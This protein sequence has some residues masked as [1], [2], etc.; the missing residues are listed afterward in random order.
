MMTKPANRIRPYVLLAFSLLFG[1]F[2]LSVLRDSNQKRELEKPSI[3][4]SERIPIDLGQGKEVKVCV[5]KKVF[6]LGIDFK[7]D[8][9]IPAYVA[10]TGRMSNKELSRYGEK[11]YKYSR[12]EDIPYKVLMMPDC[13]SDEPLPETLSEKVAEA[14]YIVA[15]YIHDDRYS[16]KN[17]NLQYGLFEYN[18]V[19][20]DDPTYR[21]CPGVY[22]PERNFVVVRPWVLNSK[23]GSLIIAEQILVSRD[24]KLRE[25]FSQILDGVAFEDPELK[26]IIEESEANAE[27]VLISW[28]KERIK[29]KAGKDDGEK[30]R[31]E[32]YSLYCE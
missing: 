10:K 29:S 12:R 15:S 17:P 27:R 28:L 30:I 7:E 9:V 18:L 6:C 11:F 4:D 26:K 16:Y 8:T 25:I 23:I 19:A 1:L 3:G 20:S 13:S 24:V 21:I 22:W 31:L 14:N 32:A 2:F 5:A